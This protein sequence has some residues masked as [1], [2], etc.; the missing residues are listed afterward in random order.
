MSKARLAVLCSHP[1]QYHAPLFRALAQDRLLDLEVFYTWSQAR[2]G[3]LYDEGFGHEV[4]WDIP[5]LAG[6]AYRFVPNVAQRPGTDHFFGLRNPDLIRTLEQARPDALLVYGWSHFSHL[7]ALRHFKA[8]VPVL[9]RGDSTLLDPSTKLRT[10]ARRLALTWIYRHVDVALAVGQNSR[11]YFSWSGMAPSQIKIVPHS[12]DNARFAD[13]SGSQHQRASDWRRE[14]GIGD[15]EITIVFAGKLQAKKDPELLLR[16]FLKLQA[17]LPTACHLVYV[18]AGE[19]EGALKT[20]AAA[21]PRVHFLPFQ[22]Q[23]V[24][25][26]VYRLGDIFVLPSRGPGETWGLALNEAM[27]SGRPVIAGSNVGA[28]RDLI[29]PHVNGWTFKSG[30]LG[31]LIA[32]L[33]EAVDRGASGLSAMGAESQ[34]MSLS[35]S[36]DGCAAQIRDAVI[37]AVGSFG[38]QPVV[39]ATQSH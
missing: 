21:C 3:R 26:A 30:D 29:R 17:D 12:I 33:G 9:F 14:L 31:D 35:W 1:I 7:Q 25:P 39:R 4:Q 22:N 16:A 36:V 27:A 11:D 37:E 28:A 2:D 24:M 20:A 13:E 5:L 23:S 34:T 19:L 10:A 32:V 18:G 38:S 6:Y 15:G 8:R